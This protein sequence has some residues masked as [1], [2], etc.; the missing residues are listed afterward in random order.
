MIGLLGLPKWRRWIVRH[1][2]P[3]FLVYPFELFLS[4]LCV[5]SGAT[6][7]LGAPAPMS[8]EALL[9]LVVVKVW[10]GTL[11]LGSGLTA[12]GIL[13]GRQLTAIYGLRLL[14]DAALVYSI[15][16]LVVGGIRGVTA[17]VITVAF[18][19]A[20]LAR[21]FQ[22]STTALIALSQGEPDDGAEGDTDSG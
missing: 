2:P 13:R 9:P 16:I 21:A 12:V 19:I 8:L 5:V 20:C 18:A 7:L 1:I 6:L 15:A 10:A 22:L 14:G 4:L 3:A 11:L 17:G